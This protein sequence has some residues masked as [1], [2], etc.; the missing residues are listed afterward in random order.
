MA[1]C[2]W[3]AHGPKTC[4]D[5]IQNVVGWTMLHPS[6]ELRESSLSI[7]TDKHARHQKHYLLPCAVTGAE[8][9][10]TRLLLRQPWTP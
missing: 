10:M 3:A 7:I 2:V 6:T 9:N 4:L 1:G 8:V 5:L